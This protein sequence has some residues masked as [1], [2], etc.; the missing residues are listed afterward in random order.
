MYSIQMECPKK[1]GVDF[2]EAGQM[3]FQCSAGSMPAEESSI[4]QSAHRSRKKKYG[5]AEKDQLGVD[6]GSPG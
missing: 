1:S 3:N 4:A 6:W 2:K 5:G